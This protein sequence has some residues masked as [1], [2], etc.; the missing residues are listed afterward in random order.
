MEFY[1][2][3]SLKEFNDLQ[4]KEMERHKWIQ[5]EKAGRDLGQTCYLEWIRCH[6]EGFRRHLN[7]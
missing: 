7:Q 3:L 5:S 6:G 1:M 2:K 4:M